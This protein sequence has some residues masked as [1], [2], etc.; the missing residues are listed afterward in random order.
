M[1][2]LLLTALIAVALPAS[3]AAKPL[4]GFMLICT[5]AGLKSVPADTPQREHG[6][7]CAHSFCETRRKPAALP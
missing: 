6:P 1:I 7:P 2:R 3:I 5:R 4:P